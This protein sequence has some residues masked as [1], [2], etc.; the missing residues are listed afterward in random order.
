MIALPRPEY[1]RPQFERPEWLNLNGEWG[2][3]FDDDDIGLKAGWHRH[4]AFNRRIIVPFAYQT[5]LSGIHEIDFHDVVWYTREFTLPAGWA[6]Q[7]VLLH[8]G[9]VD[10]RAWVWV[11][12]VGVTQHEGGN[13]PFHADITHALQ[14]GANHIIVRVEDSSTDLEQPRGKQYWERDSASI[15]YTRTT[16]IWQTVWLEP[17]HDRYIEYVNITPDIDKGQ[18]QLEVVLNAFAPALQIEAQVML[19]GRNIVTQ[20]YTAVARRG[21][22]RLMLGTTEALQLWSPE[23]PV[24]YDLTIRLLQGNDLL[25]EVSSYFGMRKISVENGQV[26]LNNQPYYMRLVLDQGYHPDG[27]L[28]FPSDEAI[29]QDVVLTKALGFNGARKHQKVEEPRYLYWADHLGLLVW[30]E[31]AAA[32]QYSEAAVARITHEWQAAVKRD[33][34]HPSIVA[35]VPINESWGVP[36]LHDDPRQV[37]H[38]MTLYYLIRSLDPTRLVISNDG[39]EH[40]KTDLLTIHDYEGD[41]EVL[42]TRYATITDILQARPAKRALYAADFEHTGEPI[43]VTEFGGIAYQKDAQQGWGYTTATDHDEFIRRYQA[44]IAALIASP[45]VQGFCYTQLTDVEQEINGLLTYDRQPKV[46]LAIIKAITSALP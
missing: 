43:L 25:D 12:G 23:T 7:R 33:F 39:W 2:F 22:T 24:L 46:N 27:L 8:F 35:W 9:A 30:G 4:A 16:G 42:R 3:E 37:D 40:A 17:V 45:L 31:M 11:N 18:V 26:L 38:L 44:V 10:Y 19:Q 28:T 1:P 6:Q 5:R 14:P 21:L 20:S 34:N 32:Y 36:N 13:V 41:E 29:Q 15:F